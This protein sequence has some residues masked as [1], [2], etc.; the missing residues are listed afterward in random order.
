MISMITIGEKNNGAGGYCWSFCISS[1]DND[2]NDFID[3]FDELEIS[4][5]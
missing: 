3:G 1:H 2:E 4:S 5:R